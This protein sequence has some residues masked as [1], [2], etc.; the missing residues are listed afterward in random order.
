MPR[1]QTTDLFIQTLKSTLGVVVLAAA[2]FVLILRILPG[3]LDVAT[4]EAT[5]ASSQDMIMVFRNLAYPEIAADLGLAGND[6]PMP[7][8]GAALERVDEKVRA[9]AADTK[10]VKLKIF[11]LKGSIIYSSDLAQIG[12]RFDQTDEAFLHALRGRS[13]SEIEHLDRYEGLNGPMSDVVLAATYVPIRDAT[14][15]I[16]G[17]V[18]IYVDRTE[19]QRQVDNE[20]SEVLAIIIVGFAALGAATFW[21]IWSQLVRVRAGIRIEAD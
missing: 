8:A 17:V 19:V 9:F 14:G 11:C 3:A 21:A 10:I 13:F 4:K 18:E 15:S 7:L 2:F 1:R 12:D 20:K 5:A 16:I 6:M